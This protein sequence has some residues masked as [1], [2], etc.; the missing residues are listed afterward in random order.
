MRMV[1]GSKAATF[2]RP[3]PPETRSS[4]TLKPPD[5]RL[6]P[7][8]I[9]ACEIIAVAEGASGFIEAAKFD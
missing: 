9:E 2:S 5:N 8:L 7:A 1:S 6:A 4:E 3:P